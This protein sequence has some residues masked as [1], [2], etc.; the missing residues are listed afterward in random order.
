MNCA[1]AQKSL[2]LRSESRDDRIAGATKFGNAF[3]THHKVLNLPNESCSGIGGVVVEVVVQ[4]M[5]CQG[6]QS[7]Q[8]KTE[9][10]L[11]TSIL[12]ARKNTKS[13][14]H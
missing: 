3:A 14:I 12:P 6:K 10:A 7:F 4:D 8:C 13:T 11:D 5:T 1:D 9:N 2:A